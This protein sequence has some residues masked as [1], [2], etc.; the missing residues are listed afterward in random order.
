MIGK[1]C[2]HKIAGWDS[3]IA[4]QIDRSVSSLMRQWNF[5]A[6]EQFWKRIPRLRDFARSYK[7]ILWDIET[8]PWVQAILGRQIFDHILK[9]PTTHSLVMRDK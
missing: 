1:S 5:R 6:I 2:S 4:L 8:D 7:N 3:R 9:E